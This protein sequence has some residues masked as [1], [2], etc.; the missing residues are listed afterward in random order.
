[1]FVI[2]VVVVVVD[3]HFIMTEKS[4]NVYDRQGDWDCKRL[5]T[6]PGC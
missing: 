2:V 5:N 3:F 1:M 4:G 6:R